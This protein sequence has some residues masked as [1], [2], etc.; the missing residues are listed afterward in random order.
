MRA[1][2]VTGT[3]TGVGKSVVCGLLARYA[4]EMGLRVITQKWVQTASPGF[5]GDIKLHLKIMRSTLSEIKQY[6]H[7]VNPYNFSAAVSPHKASNIE[8]KV[9]SREKIIKS[10]RLLAKSF[11]LVIVEG[12]G[13]LL[14]PYSKNY[15]LIDIA[16]DLKLPILLVSKNKLGAINHTLLTLEAIEKRKLHCLGVIFNNAKKEKK[17][18][19]KDNPEIIKRFSG[20]KVLAVLPWQPDFNKLYFKFKGRFKGGFFGSLD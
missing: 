10:F 14:V 12:A 1:L 17:V 6:S 20:Q 8:K 2:F 13:G 18:I 16:S 9:I 19:L 11:D 3:D 15:L 4:K 5:S 7:A